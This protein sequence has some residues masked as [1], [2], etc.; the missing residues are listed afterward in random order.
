MPQPSQLGRKLLHIL[1]LL[2]KDLRQE[3]RDWIENQKEFD[4]QPWG[5]M[6]DVL[7]TATETGTVEDL[8]R[9][10]LATATLPDQ[11]IR[12]EPQKYIAVRLTQL[13]KL[14]FEFLS[15]RAYAKHPHLQA[16]ML[17]RQWPWLQD[18]KYL[19]GLYGNALK[20]IGPQDSGLPMQGR[21]ELEMMMNDHLAKHS[22]VPGRSHL[23]QVEISLD[24]FF[25]LHK[26]VYACANLVERSLG[27]DIPP[28][29]MIAPVLTDVEEH[30]EDYPAV[31]RAYFN[32]YH[33]LNGFFQGVENQDAQFEAY[34]K[35]WQETLSSAI[36]EA[37]D[38]F[39]FGQNYCILRVQGGSEEHRQQVVKMYEQALKYQLFA[40][41]S[42][43]SPSFFKNA[44]ELFCVMGLINQAAQTSQQ[45][46]VKLNPDERRELFA[47]NQ[48]V[49]QFYTGEYA[50][51]ARE[52]YQLMGEIKHLAYRCGA[53]IYH[54]RAL[55]KTG[56]Y[57]FL[58]DTLHAFAQFVY[59][60]KSSL[61]SK[62]PRYRRFIGY[63]NRMAQ[64]M[65]GAPGKVPA[66]MNKILQDLEE[67][68]EAN[69]HGWLRGEL[70]LYIQDL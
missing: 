69:Q 42:H 52:M 44:I 61:G 64:V 65:L 7:E 24:Q 30:Y 45:Y 38:L 29:R 47:Y 2:G 27:A 68:E 58:M 17:I 40:E 56:Q 8:D 39:S 19:K 21:L 41:D 53:R 22:E 48:L 9:E 1:Y 37:K 51:V 20:H 6:L 50:M 57:E 35:E 25:V 5:K 34:Y 23:D 63:L 60:N 16:L 66:K 49:I 10:A 33:M 15:F 13:R 3:F 54:C 46:Q 55:W 62:A 4:H 70:S 26:L 59:R 36:P 67:K 18:G 31:V 11:P 32:A 12:S 14:L 28:T 43:L